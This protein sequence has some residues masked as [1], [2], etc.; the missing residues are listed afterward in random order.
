M[1][2][3]EMINGQDRGSELPEPSHSA[4]RPLRRLRLCY[5]CGANDHF[6]AR[7]PRRPRQAGARINYRRQNFT[8]PGEERVNDATTSRGGWPVRT[9]LPAITGAENVQATNGAL[10]TERPVAVV[11]PSQE[12]ALNSNN[13]VELQEEWPIVDLSVEELEDCLEN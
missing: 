9:L 4:I 5:M 11:E 6:K 7:S 13:D 2:R 12:S 1:T 3:M 10:E 8:R